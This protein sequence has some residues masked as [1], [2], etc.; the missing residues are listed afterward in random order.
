MRCCMIVALAALWL[1]EVAPAVEAARPAKPSRTLAF[2][3]YRDGQADIWKVDV[4]SRRERRLSA[5]PAT[6]T[7]PSWSPDGRRILFVS[8]RDGTQRLYDMADD[9]SDVRPLTPPGW[10]DVRAAEWAPDGS[11]VALLAGPTGSSTSLYLVAAAGGV[12][13]LLHP[14]VVSMGRFGEGGGSGPLALSWA[15]DSSRIAFSDR[16]PDDFSGLPAIFTIRPD[17]T[18]LTQVSPRDSQQYFFPQWSP[19]GSHIAITRIVQEVHWA[20][21]FRADGTSTSIATLRDG[22]FYPTWS[23]DST[24]LVLDAH[25]CPNFG[26]TPPDTRVHVYTAHADGSA[27]APFDGDPSLS[28]FGARYSPDG[29]RVAFEGSPDP[30][31]F[32]TCADRC[33]SDIYVRFADGSRR[34]RLTDSPGAD[35]LLDWRPTRR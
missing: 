22:T 28:T 6:D 34:Q 3:S 14:D 18:G 12:P 27:L 23:P 24:R 9:G 26:C 11:S 29:E 15:P 19:D 4:V 21:S 33:D 17:G 35:T 30:L 1:L 2:V 7:L 20:G 8:A 31:A 25:H 16:S 13:T 10:N 32:Q 5:S